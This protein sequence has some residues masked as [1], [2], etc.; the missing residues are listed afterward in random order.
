M[1][2][3]K[4]QKKTKSGPDWEVKA[5]G[6]APVPEDAYSL[7]KWFNEETCAAF[8]REPHTNPQET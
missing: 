3:Q 1:A 8:H 4:T 6:Y 7:S 5:L 2:V